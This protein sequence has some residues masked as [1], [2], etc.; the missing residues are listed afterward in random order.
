[1]PPR[2]DVSVALMTLR[3][4]PGIS[5]VLQDPTHS[6]AHDA[7]DRGHA[8]SY[9]QRF[10]HELNVAIED[11]GKVHVRVLYPISNVIGDVNRA[12]ASVGIGVKLDGK[13]E[14]VQKRVAFAVGDALNGTTFEYQGLAARLDARLD[15]G[16]AKFTVIVQSPDLSA[17]GLANLAGFAL[18]WM[19]KH[20]L[21]GWEGIVPRAWTGE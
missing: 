13:S 9:C 17:Y 14:A 20:P 2:S 12:L 6:V 18:P 4:V 16:D 3:E 21:T 10:L 5:S 7:R 15:D 11:G 1:M 8:F 19:L